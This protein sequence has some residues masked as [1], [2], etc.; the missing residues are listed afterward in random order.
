MDFLEVFN[1]VAKVAIIREDGAPDATSYD[2]EPTNLG[3][4]SLDMVMVIAVLT[5]VYGISDD[6]QFDNTGKF[7][8]ATVK[9]YVD[10]HKTKEPESLDEVR[11]AA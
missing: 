11:E 6:V 5:D 8:L 9:E 7:T 3:I 1:A 2:Q 4:D 10:M